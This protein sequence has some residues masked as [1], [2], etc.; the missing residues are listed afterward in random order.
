MGILC[1]PKHPALAE[2]PTE[3][4]G[5]WQWQDLLQNSEA[6]IIDDAPAEFRPIVQ[7]VP[8]FNN[9][10]KLS[11]IFEAKVGKGKLIVSTLNLQK[12]IENR[13]EAKQLLH[14]LLA[15]MKSDEFLPTNML[16]G[17]P[18]LSEHGGNPPAN[19]M[20]GRSP[21]RPNSLDEKILNKILKPVP[22]AK[23]RADKPDTA[24]ALLNIKAAV[25]AP[26]ATPDQWNVSMDKVITKKDGFDYTIQGKVWR[27]GKNSV[28][29]NPHLV[30]E[31]N[32]PK[33]FVGDFYV[34]FNDFSS[35]DRGAALFFCG[36]DLGPISRYDNEGVWL[37][38]P[39]TAVMAKTGKL[40]LDARVTKGPNVVVSQIIL[41]QK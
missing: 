40:R 14:S 38:L 36:T 18:K 23:N 32:C 10:K 9:N 19:Q 29:H 12:N 8:D 15:Y 7:F 34:H 28:W 17:D 3:S 35:E 16:A 39:V 6:L 33:D 25:N 21:Q 2:F 22:K 41:I 37:K 31:I 1:D 4:F 20:E 30:I 26:M 5:D 11:A 24:N 13:R 27:Q